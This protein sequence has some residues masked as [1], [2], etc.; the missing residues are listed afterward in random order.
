MQHATP[1]HVIGSA[2]LAQVELTGTLCNVVFNSVRCCAHSAGLADEDSS[3]SEQSM[4]PLY[5]RMLA[6]CGLASQGGS[7][8]DNGGCTF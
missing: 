5:G 1:Q 2:V 7:F 4:L 8:L 3:R 6:L